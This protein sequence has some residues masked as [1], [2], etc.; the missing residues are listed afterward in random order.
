VF[1]HELPPSSVLLTE[2]SGWASALPNPR[3]CQEDRRL[4]TF[5]EGGKEEGFHGREPVTAA[6]YTVLLPNLFY[7]FGKPPV[8]DW[9]AGFDG[10]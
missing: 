6:G 8:V 9:A 4:S 2:L 10:G 7:R 5:P 3:Q 1:S